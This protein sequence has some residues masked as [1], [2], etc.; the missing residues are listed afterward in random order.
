MQFYLIYFLAEE[1]AEELKKV[2]KKD[3]I[4]FF[5]TYIKEGGPKRKR[6]II[7]MFSKP[8][9]KDMKSKDSTSSK[10]TTYVHDVVSFKNSR[11]LYPAFVKF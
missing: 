5:E 3:L 8:Y 10:D 11:E 1:E 9:H 6:L 2:T 7:Q 4:S